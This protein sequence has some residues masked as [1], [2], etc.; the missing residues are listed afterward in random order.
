MVQIDKTKGMDDKMNTQEALRTMDIWQDMCWC[1]EV[2]E[3]ETEED[4]KQFKSEIVKALTEYPKLQE[5]VR[6]LSKPSIRER[7]LENLN[8]HLKQ[9]LENF[10]EE[11]LPK[12][13]ILMLQPKPHPKY[14]ITEQW[15]DASAAFKL[16]LK[17]ILGDK[18]DE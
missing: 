2:P 14:G 7:E 5:Q 16:K 4:M 3:A 1:F 11:Q 12:F 13:R 15:G 9:R 8:K 6:F 10:I 17:Q 18:D